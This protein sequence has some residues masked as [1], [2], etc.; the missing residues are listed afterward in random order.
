MFVN[1]HVVKE[2][3]K[4]DSIVSDDIDTDTP[5]YGDNTGGRCRIKVGFVLFWEL[6]CKCF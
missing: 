3:V 4:K 6:K 2:N 1:K 5:S